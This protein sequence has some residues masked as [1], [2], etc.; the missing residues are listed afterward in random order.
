[1]KVIKFGGTSVGSA[2][3]IRKV[4]DIISDYKSQGIAFAV[5]ASA[6][7]GVT[8]SL[9]TTATLASQSDEKYLKGLKE[10]EE[11]HIAIIRALMEAKVQ[12]QVFAQLKSM[13]NELEDLLHGVFLIKELSERTLDL[14]LSFGERLSNYILAETLKQQGI[15]AQYLDARRVIKTD[16]HF[17][18]AN[19]NFEETDIL[20][21]NHFSQAKELQVITGFIGSTEKDETTTL[22]RGGSDYTAAIVAAA[23][24]AEEIE[25]WTDVDGIM[26]ADPRKVKRAFTLPTV[27]YIEAME[28]SHFG[29]K[30]IYP[31]TLQPAFSKKIPIRIRNT[32][33][34][35]HEGT[36]ISEKT[37]GSG[38]LIKGISS[39]DNIALITLQGSGLVGVAGV[40][41]RLFG[42]LAKHY[43]NII[44]ITQASSEHSITFAVLPQF[45]NKVR[46]VVEE[47]FMHE[48][49]QGSVDPV[50]I[51]EQGAIVAVIGENM[52]QTVGVSAQL[53]GALG[54]NGISVSA[55][56]Q[57]SSEQNI[58]VVINQRDL[59]KALNAL[60]ESFF[61]SQTKS[62]NLFVVGPGL[63]GGTLLRQIAKQADYLRT[64][65]SINVRLVG[66]ANS[67]KMVLDEDK[68][69]LENWQQRLEEAQDPMDLEAFTKSIIELNLPNSV[70]VDCTASPK[71]ISQ[72]IP[73]LEENV[74]VVTP[75]KYANAGPLENYRRLHEAAS[76]YGVS[77]C[78]ETNVGAGLP[79][80]STLKDLMHSGDKILKIEAVLSGSVSFI[81]N[82]FHEGTRFSKIVQEAKERGFTE[83]DP[84]EDLSGADVA[85][86]ILILARESGMAIEAHEVVIHNFLPAACLDAPSIPDFFSA[87]EEADA[88]FE[89]RRREAEIAGKV[90]RFVA[91]LENGQ[92]TI[93]MQEVD[94]QHP[95]FSLSG[96]DNMIVFTTERYRERPLVIKGPGA[97]S[98]VTAAGIFAEIIKCST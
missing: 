23:L 79:V 29:A 6:V 51:E 52:R 61:L 1:V 36:L 81:F 71:I 92:A 8:N 17:G 87:L 37:D 21:R 57:G 53:F 62:L 84:R 59:S 68:I 2:E 97:G 89:L 35:E 75:N 64:Q 63:V 82:S 44:L 60:H 49:Q 7:S 90:L 91:T 76:R 33:N 69:D 16:N 47:E 98:E 13:I 11:K 56:A 19:V 12:S 67:R 80:I 73:L 58:S 15:P 65:L 94:T 30:V 46:K 45:A 42:A 24:T 83:P 34:R 31:P 78:Y 54:R 10:I 85:R 5:V 14:V 26:T 96:S 39:I 74:S 55:T 9:I 22:G 27:S 66:L 72:Y 70:F 32:F 38:F 40:A 20:I 18:T 77:F 28:M 88:F 86:K 43:I 25:I 95:F 50:H 3:S 93:G 48:I 4:L 41:A